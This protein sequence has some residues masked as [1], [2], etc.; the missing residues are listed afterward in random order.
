MFRILD[1]FGHQKTGSTLEQSLYRGEL[2]LNIMGSC[3]CCGSK[4]KKRNGCSCAGKAKPTHTCQHITTK[5][6]RKKQLELEEQIKACKLFEELNIRLELKIEQLLC[7]KSAELK[8]EMDS[9][10]EFAIPQ[11]VPSLT[12]RIRSKLW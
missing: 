9:C 6:L 8:Q 3:T 1:T 4:G 5:L 2:F 11:K 10:Q 12:Q 7:V